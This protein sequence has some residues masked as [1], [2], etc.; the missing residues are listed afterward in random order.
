MVR[1]EIDLGRPIDAKPWLD[2]FGGHLFGNTPHAP[3]VQLVDALTAAGCKQILVEHDQGQATEL[4]AE[5][6]SSADKR[7]AAFQ[8]AADFCKVSGDTPPVDKGQSYLVMGFSTFVA[9]PANYKPR[10]T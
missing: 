4:F 6:P 3:C 8:A 5:L 10:G 1:D 9:P 2:E 7:K